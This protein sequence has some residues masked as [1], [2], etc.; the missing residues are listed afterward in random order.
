M[1]DCG[2]PGT[3]VPNMSDEDNRSY[4]AKFVGGEM[5]RVEVRVSRGAEI[6]VKL[7]NKILAEPNQWQDPKWDIIRDHGRKNVKIS[8]NG[9]AEFTWLEWEEFKKAI[10]EGFEALKEKNSP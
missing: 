8:M 2:V 9:P 6:L 5:P 10:E 1:S 7:K 3:Y 4:K